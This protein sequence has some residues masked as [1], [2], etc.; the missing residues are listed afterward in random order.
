M[1]EVAQK[2]KE[3]EEKWYALHV[4][5]GQENKVM[6]YLQNEIKRTG[7]E[8]RITQIL[9]PQ[10]NV[11]EMKDGKKVVK[12]KNFFPGYVL[13]E[14]ILDKETRHLIL[15]APG[16]INFLGSQNSPQV[17]HPS[18]IERILGRTREKEEKE[19]MAVPFNVGD[20]VKVIDGPFNDFSGFIEEINPE[21]NKVKVLVSIFG[22]PTPVELDFLQVEQEK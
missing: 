12:T 8:N 14:M 7:L 20:T 10:E 19:F 9:V 1:S 21:K 3:K 5:S 18:E 6:A 17:I 15:S 11:V 22:R 13:A 4:Y 2:V 16:V